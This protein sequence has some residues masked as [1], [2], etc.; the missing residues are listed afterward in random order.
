MKNIILSTVLILFI[1]IVF[2]GLSF[3]QG[4]PI[5]DVAGAIDDMP[6]ESLEYFK[7]AVSSKVEDALFFDTFLTTDYVNVGK[8]SYLVDLVCIIGYAISKESRDV[9]KDLSVKALYFVNS[10]EQLTNEENIKNKI[11]SETFKFYDKSGKVVYGSVSYVY[12]SEYNTV[13]TKYISYE[14]TQ[15]MFN[16]LRKG[17]KQLLGFGRLLEAFFKKDN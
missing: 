1:I 12:T 15:K 11:K 5:I 3:S 4:L 13:P 14:D 6:I 10:L 8:K 2:S 7:L 16:S 9:A 17:Y